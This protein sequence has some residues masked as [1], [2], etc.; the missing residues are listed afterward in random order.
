[1]KETLKE[2]LAELEHKQ[3]SH[4]TK[5][6]LENQRKIMN[7]IRWKRQMR[8][9]Y[10]ELT[11]EEKDLDRI[12]ADK[13]LDLFEEHLKELQREI[14]DK[15]HPAIKINLSGFQLHR[16]IDKIFNKDKSGFGRS[17]GY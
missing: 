1:M 4:W 12:W 3:W 8:T 5:Y 16:I 2:Q 13:V 7:R 9:P 10:T 11:E 6:M 17:Y 15:F 14:K